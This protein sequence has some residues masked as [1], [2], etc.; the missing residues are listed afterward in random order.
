MQSCLDLGGRLAL[1][2]LLQPLPQRGKQHLSRAIDFAGTASKNP[3]SATTP[4]RS[5]PW[6]QV[7][8]EWH[9]RCC[10]FPLGLPKA[11]IWVHALG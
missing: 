6:G 3:S 2:F 11:A 5:K 10:A 7:S 1:S 8:A 4:S 9:P